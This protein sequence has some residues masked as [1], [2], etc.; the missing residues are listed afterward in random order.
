MFEPSRLAQQ[1]LAD[2]YARL[3][4]TVRRRIDSIQPDTPFTSEAAPSDGER[5]A[6]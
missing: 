6:Q 3:I 2:A 5:S 1:Y 4:P